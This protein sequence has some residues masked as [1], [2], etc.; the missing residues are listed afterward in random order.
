M[1]GFPLLLIPLAIVNILAFLMPGVP[2]SATL[3]TLA[4]P[5]RQ[6]LVVT[7]GDAVLLLAL[8]LLFGEI[9]KAV[10]PGGR[11]LMDHLLALIVAAAAIGELLM[12][13]AFANGV[14]LLLA[15][16]TVVEFA[17]GIVLGVGRRPA[18]RVA[19]VAVPAS[20]ATAEPPQPE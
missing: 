17:A 16:L 6:E 7:L 19:P 18:P 8:A 2:L 15:A 4:L 1:F 9:A 10:R 3:A 11:I 5:S 12:L 20:P 14:C 13:P